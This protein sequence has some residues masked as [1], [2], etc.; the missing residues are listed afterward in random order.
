[1][2]INK[3]LGAEMRRQRTIKNLSL[4][5]VADRMGVNSRNTISL[6]ELGRKNITVGDIL[7]FCRAVGCELDP[8]VEI[9][10]NARLQR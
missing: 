5:Q 4:A 2:N 7:T 1:M 9:I 10:E 6:M 8:F 3:E